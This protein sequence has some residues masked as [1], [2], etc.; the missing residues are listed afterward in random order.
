MVYKVF[1]FFTF[2]DPKI[3]LKQEVVWSII[4]D[5]IKFL[6]FIDK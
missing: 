6:T 5:F 2:V 3:R 4:G 1:F